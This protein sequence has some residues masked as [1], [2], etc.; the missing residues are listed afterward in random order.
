MERFTH[1]PRR[2]LRR[3]GQGEG[4]L[5][6]MDKVFKVLITGT[7]CKHG[8]KTISAIYPIYTFRC[9]LRFASLRP[10]SL[11][12]RPDCHEPINK[13]RQEAAQRTEH[14]PWDTHL[15]Q[16]CSSSSPPSANEQLPRT[17][18]SLSLEWTKK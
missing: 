15:G 13:Y 17:L 12:P 9:S 2:S 16:G 4:G 14:S 3:V 5:Y 8:N 18:P 1:P 10:A 11:V 6:L 7:N